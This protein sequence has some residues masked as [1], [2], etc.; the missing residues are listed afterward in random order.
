LNAGRGSKTADSWNTFVSALNAAKAAAEKA[1]ATQN[2]VDAALAALTSARAKLVDESPISKVPE[3]TATVAVTSEVKEAADGV[4]AGGRT[5]TV[6]STVS[7]EAVAEIA[8]QAGAVISDAK[9]KA[10]EKIAA[11]TIS[12]GET[13]VA[14]IRIAAALPADVNA[15]EVK[16]TVINVSASAI[17][18][19]AEESAKSGN[20]N[21]ELVLTVDAGIGAVTL[22]AAELAA[23]AA[24]G[25]E[26]ISVAVIADARTVDTPLPSA[27][28]NAVPANKVPF[29]IE[30]S[31]DNTPVT[32]R[33]ASPIAVTVPYVKQGGA[34]KKVV[35]YHVAAD[36]TKTKLDA[37]YADGRLTFVTDRI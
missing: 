9:A 37:T 29:A 27:Q 11:G 23:L 30:I 8:Q 13:V 34:D 32:G 4:A 22:D 24:G 5:K 7:A 36:G 14:E 25:G 20:E 1:D 16:E 17:R 33:L 19:I 12:A 28:A 35:L 15:G 10:A 6:E 3:A 21:V 26:E 31:V 2:E 18:A